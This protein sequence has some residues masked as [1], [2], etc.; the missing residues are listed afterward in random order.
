MSPTW[1]H[2]VGEN[3]LHNTT[4]LQMALVLYVLFFSEML[5]KT[6]F[7]ADGMPHQMVKP[8]C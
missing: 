4:A 3:I 1:L 5:N 8:L 6:L 7:V 2:Q